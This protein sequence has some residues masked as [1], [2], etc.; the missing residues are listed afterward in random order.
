MPNQWICGEGQYPKTFLMKGQ[1]AK[2]AKLP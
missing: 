2:G 1:P